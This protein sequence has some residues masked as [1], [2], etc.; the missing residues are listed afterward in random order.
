MKFMNYLIALSFLIASTY[1]GAEATPNRTLIKGRIPIQGKVLQ[2]GLPQDDVSFEV[3]WVGE[4]G[5]QWVKKLISKMGTHLFEMRD[6]PEW[7]GIAKGIIITQFQGIAVALKEPSL[8]DEFAIFLTPERLYVSTVNILR[9]YTFMGWAWQTCLL[10][11]LLVF[12]AIVYFF[13]RNLSVALLL[14]FGI[15]LVGVDLRSAYDHFSILKNIEDDGYV[16][17]IKDVKEWTEINSNEW[18]LETWTHRKLE[19]RFNMFIP[20]YLQE[21]KFV[22]Y[23]TDSQGEFLVTIEDGGLIITKRDKK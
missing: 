11:S 5:N 15:T 23:R 7:K 14:G 20:Y 4:D 8:K 21:F 16:K 12:M 6:H 18:N 3:L 2:L 1:S 9:G 10:F 13:K 19:G 22:P 17:L